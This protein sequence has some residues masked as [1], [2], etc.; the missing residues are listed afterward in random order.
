MG[1]P[2]DIP[3]YWDRML[4]D[5]SQVTNP[6]ID[7]LR[8]PMELKTFLGAKPEKLE[9]EPSPDGP[10]LKTKITPQI[11]LNYPMMF[12]AMSF[13]AINVIT[14]YSIHYTKL[15]EA[16]APAA[17]TVRAEGGER[18]SLDLRGF[19]ADV[20]LSELARFLDQALLKGRERVEIVHGKGSGALRREVHAFLKSFPPV[21]H[22]FLATEEEGGDGKTI[23]E[24]S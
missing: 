7:P 10:V 16:S 18:M 2:V 23:V 21:A 6:S 11:E 19:R 14:S 24:F 12:A 5:A 17:V 4:L 13:G 9:I 20:A 3:V 15:Y 1:S 8:E 22:F